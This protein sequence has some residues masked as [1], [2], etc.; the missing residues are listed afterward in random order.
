VV[1]EILRCRFEQISGRY[2]R[3]GWGIWKSEG[4]FGPFLFVFDYSEWGLRQIY[5]K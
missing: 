3:E 1:R 5:V 4:G 2:R